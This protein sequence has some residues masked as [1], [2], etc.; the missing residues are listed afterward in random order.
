MSENTTEAENGRFLHALA[1]GVC[2]VLA[3][4]AV[5]AYEFL[6]IRLMARWHGSSADI[7][8]FEISVCL[9]GLAGGYWMGGKLA[10]RFRS[11]QVF[12]LVM[13][14]GGLTA[15]PMEFLVN[16][17]GEPLIKVDAWRAFHPMATAAVSSLVPFLI[18]GTVV[19]QAI[20]LHVRDMEKVGGSAGWIASLSTFGSIAGVLVTTLVLIR[21]V[22]VRES[23]YVTSGVLIALGVAIM[24]VNSL[25]GRSGARVAAVAGA[26][27]L[28]M[29]TAHAEVLYDNYSEYHHILVEDIDGRRQVRFDSDVQTIMSLADPNVGGFEYTEFFH[30][31]VLLN[32]TITNALF[33][34]L[35][36]GTGPKTFF[37]AYK[38]MQLEAVEIDPEVVR[39]ARE[40]FALPTDPR[41]KVSTM[42]ARQYLLR[43][44]TEYG[45]IMV[46]AYASGPYGATLPAHLASQ[47]F[48]K[49]VH[50]RL[51]N[52][53][54]MV[55]NVVG[56]Y[57]TMNS[58]VVRAMQTTIESVFQVTYAFRAKSTYNTVYVA[59]KFTPE[60]WDAEG[61]PTLK[62][63]PYG[64]W[65]GHPMTGLNFGW[66][67][68]EFAKQGGVIGVPN[69][70]VRSTQI[71][72][73]QTMKRVELILTDNYAPVDLAIRTP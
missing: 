13:I 64:P 38:G 72:R 9:L 45:A 10:D 60:S 58:D 18:L 37:N 55:Y 7:W 57:G 46:D 12:G 43:S 29:P 28:L 65:M 40:Y 25:T 14:L 15:L 22:G 26:L 68:Q 6:A 3:G 66:L 31:P 4:A 5:M 54:C 39:V 41:L 8:A 48:L 30:L 73:V 52:G 56:R 42:D 51:Q 17:V 2:V 44:N 1:L 67:F 49:I 27:L 50:E 24:V 70:K 21:H 59:M 69:F 16:L 71:A 63:W 33:L 23:I 47:E 36:G 19:P 34:G 35:G 62:Q 32:P 61:K 53:G 11:W 20:R